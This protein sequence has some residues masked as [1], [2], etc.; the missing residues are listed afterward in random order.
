[1]NEV[2]SKW[3]HFAIAILVIFIVVGIQQIYWTSKIDIDSREM[4]DTREI[5]YNS[6]EDNTTESWAVN[7]DSE[8][9]TEM[10]L[11][12][13]IDTP[14]CFEVYTNETIELGVFSEMDGIVYT[15]TLYGKTKLV[16]DGLPIM[17]D[18]DLCNE[19][20]QG[21]VVYIS[22]ELKESI[23]VTE[24]NVTV[25]QQSWEA[26]SSDVRLASHIDRWFYLIEL[27][28]FAAGIYIT[29]AKYPHRN[30]VWK[31]TWNI[32][33]FEFNSEIKTSRTLILAIFFTLFITGM[34]WLLGDLQ[35]EGSPILGS[36]QTPEDAITRLSWFTFFVVSLAAIAVSSDN[37]YKERQSNTISLLL[38]R[39]ISR[40]SIILGKGIGLT[41]AVGA[42]AF[43]AM[44]VGLI[45]MNL[46][47]QYARLTINGAFIFIF[48]IQKL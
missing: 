46:S 41:G 45:L 25:Y 13:S 24:E 44:L 38:S 12:G 29:V 48:V 33:K 11:K 32:A 2:D 22:A 10:V 34:G 16:I 17:V 4:W 26:K 19:F 43:V 18:G 39:P 27:F 5:V 47:F 35:K 42:P 36:V 7:Y 1:M 21:E 14:P 8:N 3:K 20:K 28:I 37:I 31:D 30:K 9:S 6:G 40:E 15:E 23:A